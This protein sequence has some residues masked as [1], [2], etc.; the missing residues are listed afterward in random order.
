LPAFTG[1]HTHRSAINAGVRLHGA[2]VHFVTPELDAGPIIAQAIVPVL[3]GDTE[4]VLATRVLEQEHCLYPRV[5][6]WFI[7]G[8]V[9][10]KSGR[11]VL[12][13]TINHPA[14]YAIRGDFS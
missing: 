12:D 2:T 5:V 3:P 8:K 4:D 13:E 10:L 14:E 11:V 6:R 9:G 1:L 7:E